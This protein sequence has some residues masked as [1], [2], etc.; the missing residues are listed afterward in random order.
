MT[1]GYFAA[2]LMGAYFLAL[3][4]FLVVLG[5]F[6]A[7]YFDGYCAGFAQASDQTCVVSANTCVCGDRVVARGLGGVPHPVPTSSTQP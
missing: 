1:E 5:A 2:A 4:V 7:N 3:L 6:R